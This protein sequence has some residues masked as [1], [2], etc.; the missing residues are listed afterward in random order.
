MSSRDIK[1]TQAAMEA[2]PGLASVFGR[3]FA[4]EPMMYWP[5]GHHGN[6]AERFTRCFRYFLEKAIP[7]GTVRQAGPS[8][9][10]AVWDSPEQSENWGEHPWNQPRIT[11]LAD[12]GGASYEAF[13]D[14][15]YSHTPPE[16]LWQ[17]DSIAVDP[18]YQGRGYGGALIA[19]GLD[20]ARAGGVGAFLST[21]T[22]H[23]VTIYGRSG[24]RV[25][26][27]GDYPGGG[28]HVW[29]MRWEP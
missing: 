28:P 4:T 3:A 15:V 13:W 19:D 17:L 8:I 26:D 24:F 14:W 27:E 7:R 23:N 29:F 9:G 25:V 2:P 11:R 12:D 10:A 21:G 1:V 5:L 22:E 6:P 16:P 18:A 20:R